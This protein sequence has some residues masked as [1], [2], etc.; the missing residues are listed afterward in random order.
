MFVCHFAVAVYSIAPS[1]TVFVSWGTSGTLFY[2][3]VPKWTRHKE[4]REKPRGMIGRNGIE[5]NGQTKKQN[6]ILKAQLAEAQ[7]ANEL[8]VR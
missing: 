4:K 5:L 6:E 3:G 1:P 2:G 8:L 7:M